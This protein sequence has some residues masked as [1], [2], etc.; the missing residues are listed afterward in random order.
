MG[1]PCRGSRGWWGAKQTRSS[2]QIEDGEGGEHSLKTFRKHSILYRNQSPIEGHRTAHIRGLMKT[3][4]FVP[5]CFSLRG[6]PGEHN[7][8]EGADGGNLAAI[9]SILI[10]L[11]LCFL[12]R[13]LQ[14]RQPHCWGSVGVLSELGEW[15]CV[16]RGALQHRRPPLAFAAC[17]IPLLTS[18]H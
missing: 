5:L 7:G 16:A 17:L 8:T 18:P 10:G 9:P 13:G 14:I 3:K 1:F 4:L 15:G 6:F 2:L 11:S 12:V